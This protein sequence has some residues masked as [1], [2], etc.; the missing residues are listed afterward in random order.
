MTQ[1]GGDE[2]L[3]LFPSLPFLDN[4]WHDRRGFAF[5][6][7][8]ALSS[9]GIALPLGVFCY[10]Q[11]KFVPYHSV[12]ITLWHQILIAADLL[13]LWY[14]LVLI[15]KRGLGRVG[16]SIL[17]VLSG[18]VLFFSLFMAICPRTWIEKIWMPFPPA[19]LLTR[20]LRLADEPLIL[21]PPSPDLLAAMEE[22]KDQD[23]MTVLGEF[24]PGVR[25]ARRDLRDANLEGAKLFGAD[26]RGADLRGASL[27]GADL[28]RAM[29]APLG[30]S[31]LMHERRGVQ[32]SSQVSRHTCGTGGLICTLLEETDLRGADL[33]GSNLILARMRGADLRGAQLRRVE[34]TKADL[35]EAHLEG[36]VLDE[37]ELSHARLDH[38]QADRVMLRHAV[39]AYASLTN[40][41]LRNVRAGGAVF[42]EARMEGAQ[43]TEARLRG[44]EFRNA[45]L[46]GSDF[47]GASLQ[48]AKSL[49]LEAVDLRGAH[50]GGA[51]KLDFVK[52]T[53][54]RNVDFYSAANPELDVDA[55]ANC[56]GAATKEHRLLLYDEARG[57][58][59]NGWPSLAEQGTKPG[60]NEAEFHSQLAT[61]LLDLV[62]SPATKPE[63]A[64][65]LALSVFRRAA[66]EQNPGDLSLDLELA[67][68]LSRRLEARKACPRLQKVDESRKRR[69]AWR[70]RR[71]ERDQGQ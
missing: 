41:S 23:R 56:L 55:Q 28:R 29:L 14:F 3:L 16:V 58:P 66:G 8:T 49:T 24:Y 54:L 10:A 12:W 68:Q 48:G 37:A 61:R 43:L 19:T 65:G 63:E 11:Y 60:W 25:L 5:L 69:I 17:L 4:L 62:C 22:E 15:P 20:D 18:L 9:S 64:E 33:T 44:S 67:R 21:E 2:D 52:L 27:A 71:A 26:L 46:A 6:V 59:L 57:G 47:R 39:L 53:D 45:R 30:E 13:L 36:A 38:A 7:S 50:L 40:A 1:L 34:L 51:C 35:R 31:A 32:K 70:L 42:L